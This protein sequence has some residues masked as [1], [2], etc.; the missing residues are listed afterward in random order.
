ML[1]DYKNFLKKIEN[2]EPWLIEHAIK[3][4]KYYESVI[5]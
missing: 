2:V 4:I 1:I 5:K 3:M